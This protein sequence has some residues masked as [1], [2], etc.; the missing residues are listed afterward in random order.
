MGWRNDDERVR[1]DRRF[2]RDEDMG[3]SYWS[4]ASGRGGM[5]RGDREHH[6]FSNYA[7]G[8]AR[9][10]GPAYGHGGYGAGARERQMPE[11]EPWRAEEMDR[12]PYW[13]KGPKGYRRSDERIKDD[14]CDSIAQQ[15]WIDASDVEVRVESGV[16]LLTGSVASREDK[17][18]LEQLADRIQGVEDVRN[19]IRV[20]REEHR[21]SSGHNGNRNA[22]R[23]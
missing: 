14:V 23:S 18:R 13:G 6:G 1:G 7:G 17:R 9:D 10:S 3:G 19:E 4:G 11:S 8:G 22:T 16:V 21:P 12:G 15:G 20:R 5:V 2:E